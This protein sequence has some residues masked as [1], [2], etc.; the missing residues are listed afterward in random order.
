VRFD[1]R[2]D[3]S[4]R[5]GG[6]DGVDGVELER[7]PRRTPAQEEGV[8]SDRTVSPCLDL[9]RETNKRNA[10]C[11]RF[12]VIPSG[13]IALVTKVVSGGQDDSTQ[14]VPTASEAPR[15]SKLT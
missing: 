14:R 2:F 3:W 4:R 8:G 15:L 10:S 9:T 13:P 6:P 11:S 12:L 1:G 5:F 7:S